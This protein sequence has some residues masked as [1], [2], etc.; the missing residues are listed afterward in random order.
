MVNKFLKRLYATI[1]IGKKPVRSQLDSG[2]FCNVIS[3][4]T[5]RSCSGS[6]NLE[7]T[8]QVISMYNQTTLNPVGQCAL[9]L[10][11]RTTDKPYCTEFVVLEELRTLCAWI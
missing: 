9:E 5:F 6:V 11:N 7:E 10:H 1:D 3:E 4:V 8:E 2:A